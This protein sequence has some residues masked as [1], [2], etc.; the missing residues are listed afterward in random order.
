MRILILFLIWIQ[1]SACSTAD[2]SN[3]SCDFVT[4]AAESQQVREERLSRPGTVELESNRKVS[5]DTAQGIL[6]VIFG[7][8][9]RS[10]SSEETNN[11]PCL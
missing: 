5:D 9:S 4:S 11:Q 7:A 3:S 2:F 6:G 8:L 10:L 1:L